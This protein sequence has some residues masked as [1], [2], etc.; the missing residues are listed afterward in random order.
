MGTPIGGSGVFT[1][2]FVDAR[3]WAAANRVGAIIPRSVYAH[4]DQSLGPWAQRPTLEPTLRR[5]FR[6][7]R[8]PR[9]SS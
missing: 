2:L 1:E 6:S 3:C 4:A 5:L 9:R 8:L 7:E